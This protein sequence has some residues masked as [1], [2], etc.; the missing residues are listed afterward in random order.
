LTKVERGAQRQVLI[1]ATIVE[2]QLANAYQG[3]VDWSR[4]SQSGGL[5]FQSSLIGPRLSSAPFFALFYNQNNQRA[6]DVQLTVRLLEQFGD[7]RVLSSPKLMAL[8][9]QTALLKVVDNIVYFEVQ[10]QTSQAQTT[11]LTTFNTTPKTVA[12]GVVMGVTPQI[13]EDGRVSLTVRPTIS[14]VTRFVN[15]PNP[16]LASAGVTNPVPQVQT[17]EMESVLQVNN[18]QTVVLGGLMQD[19]VQR[20]RDQVPFVGNAPNLG[21]LF[22]LR[23]EKVT[24][25]ELVIFLKTTIVSN[26]SLNSDE[27]KFF[28]RFLPRAETPPDVSSVPPYFR[29]PDR[30]PPMNP[31]TPAAAR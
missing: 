28:Q 26:P 30:Q 8:N 19:D 18:G 7:T 21:D 13:S 12:V 4:V 11:A 1:E 22:A 31:D 3:G 20:S 27:L 29:A 15:D 16:Q 23:T 14:R 25:S 5:A 2:V 24:K 9:N 6:G 10:A 17:R